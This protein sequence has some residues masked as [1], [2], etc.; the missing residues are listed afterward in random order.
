LC[1]LVAACQSVDDKHFYALVIVLFSRKKQIL[2]CDKIRVKKINIYG[3]PSFF[4]R[5]GQLREWVQE[6]SGS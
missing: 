4:A 2:V 6:T 1:Q 3:T 5:R